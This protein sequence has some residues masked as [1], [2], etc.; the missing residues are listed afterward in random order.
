MIVWTRCAALLLAALTIG[1][2]PMPRA[3]GQTPLLSVVATTAMIGDA[4]KAVGGDRVKVEVLLGEGVDPHLY[5][6]TRADVAKLVRADMIVANGLNLEAQFRDT[7]EQ[8][9]KT[10][11]VVL[12]GEALPKDKLL[13]DPDYKDKP[14]PHV[15]MDPEL[16]T[17]V[18]GAVRDALVARDPAGRAVFDEGHD[19]YVGELRRLAEYSKQALASIPQEKRV[20]LTAHDA[21]SYFSPRLRHRGGRHPGRLDRERGR[22]EEDRGGGRARRFDARSRRSSSRAPCRTATSRPS[23]RARRAAGHALVIGAELFSDAMGAPGT[24]E[25]TYVG[26]IDHN[27][28]SDHPRP[29]RRGPAARPQRQARGATLNGRCSPPPPISPAAA[30]GSERTSRLEV[31]GLSVAYD[32]RLAIEDVDWRPPDSGLVAIVGPN[33]AGKSTLLK[34]I[35]GLVPTASGKCRGL[36]PA[37]RPGARPPRLRAAAGRGRLGFPGDRPRRR[38]AGHDPPGSAGSA[39]YARRHREEARAL[40]ADVGMADFANRQIGALSGGQQQRVFLARG[41][42][43]QADI[44]LFDEPL[45]GVDA[46]SEEIILEVLDGQR[47]KGRLVVCI[48]HDLGTVADRFDHVL[49]LQSPGGRRR[50]DRDAF[51]PAALA[52]AYGVPLSV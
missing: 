1:A 4:V 43:R 18:V 14:D 45:T 50:P 16:W 22:P 24:Y 17:G 6:P 51:T 46:A 33:G 15:W 12:A 21:F 9:A 26:M 40:L 31:E 7:F 42:A 19:R 36:R 39:R 8:L 30:D 23:S 41:L 13:A 34:A 11:P 20:L 27:V 37:G 49:V 48:H 44:L 2:A 52:R 38:A 47:A 28:T 29:R 25:G 10:K 32:G 35:L 3:W 5:K